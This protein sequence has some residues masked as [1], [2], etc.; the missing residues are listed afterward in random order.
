MA[1]SV[2]GVYF[3]LQSFV[4]MPVFGLT[5]ALI[6]IAAYNYGA[7]KPKRMKQ[8]VRLALYITTGVMLF[9]TL[10]FEFFPGFFL[11]MFN[12]DQ[13]MLEIGI[14]ALRTI[15]ISFCFSG[16]SIICASYFQ[17]LGRAVW[18]MIIS[19]L[20]QLVILVPAAYILMSIGGLS[21]VWFSLP[22]AEVM[23]MVLS[24]ILYAG[25]SKRVMAGF[26]A[27]D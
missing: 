6:P 22:A 4:F 15:C 11:G 17:A 9:G 19:I 16:V 7:G 21:A 10:L 25:V 2:F 5:N 20:R 26:E 12:A 8:A 1:I 14:P 27:A 3:K 23:A 24:I 18:S 13:R